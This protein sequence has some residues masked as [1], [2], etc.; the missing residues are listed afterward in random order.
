MRF[1]VVSKMTAIGL[2][3]LSAP[4]LASEPESLQ[5][6]E[7]ADH[8]EAMRLALL[9]DSIEGVPHHAA[10]IQKLAAAGLAALP[11]E[12]AGVP[13][14]RIGELEAALQ[15]VESAASNL[16]EAHGLVSAREEI[17]AL[18]KPLVK[19]RSLTGDEAAVVA[20][21]PM[22]R[23]SWIQP[24]GEIGNPYMGQ[25]MPKCGEILVDS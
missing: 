21:C 10:A 18:T 4:G 5:Y 24:A 13:E 6:S 3:A 8:Y 1:H 22:A 16:S 14:D 25:E 7:M 17:F 2:L 15:E 11:G 19:I 9:A 23:K 20:F 12:R